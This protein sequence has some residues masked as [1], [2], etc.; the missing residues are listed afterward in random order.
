M[1][2]FSRTTVHPKADCI[3]LPHITCDY[4]A[5]NN[6]PCYVMLLHYVT[7]HVMYCNVVLAWGW[8]GSGLVLA[9]FCSGL[10]L[11]WF[12][13]VSGM[14][15]AWLWPGSGLV[16]AL[17]GLGLALGCPGSGLGLAWFWPW[18]GLVLA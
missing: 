6:I 4:T 2:L 16:L 14:V 12:W 8:P 1:M 15:L 13:P 9:W 11:A 10:A 17:A 5:S 18:A 7:P 3:T